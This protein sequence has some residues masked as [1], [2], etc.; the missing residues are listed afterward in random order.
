MAQ[1]VKKVIGAGS[2][3]VT[4]GA[5]FDIEKLQK[6]CRDQKLDPEETRRLLGILD[7]CLTQAAKHDVQDQVF[8]KDLQQMGVAIENANNMTKA[9]G[10][11]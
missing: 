3:K 8:N 11:N 5:T 7:F 4:D 9:Y 1:I 10:E 6:L 2:F